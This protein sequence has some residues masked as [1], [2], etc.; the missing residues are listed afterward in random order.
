MGRGNFAGKGRSNVKY[1]ALCRESVI[2]AKTAEPIAMQFRLR[3]WV[4]PR[5]HVLDG[6]SDAPLEGAVLREK[7]WPIVK[8]SNSDVSCAKTAETIEMPFGLSTLVAQ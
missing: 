5:N 1:R 8:Y 3:I 6:S 7:E 4:G 2:C